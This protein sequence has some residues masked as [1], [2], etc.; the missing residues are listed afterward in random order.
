MVNKRE[1]AGMS[2]DELLKESTRLDGEI[3]KLRDEKR[4]V[5]R[6][7]EGRALTADAERKVAGLSDPERAALAQAI[8]TVPI[9]DTSA[10]GTPGGSGEEE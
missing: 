6:E 9:P 7:I 10:V 2:E 4:K 1:L 8:K 5:A 3:E